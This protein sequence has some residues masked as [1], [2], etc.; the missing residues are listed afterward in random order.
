MDIYLERHL[1][2]SSDSYSGAMVFHR[3]SG[4]HLERLGRSRNL[5]GDILLRFFR[6]SFSLGKEVDKGTGRVKKLIGYL[7]RVIFEAIV[8]GVILA[9]ILVYVLEIGGING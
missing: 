4:I 9:Y 8:L 6:R 5:L 7:A 3:S 1:P 2:P